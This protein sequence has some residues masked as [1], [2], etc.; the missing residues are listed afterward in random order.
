[1]QLNINNNHKKWEISSYYGKLSLCVITKDYRIDTIKIETVVK[2]SIKNEASWFINKDIN[3]Q[4]E[5]LDMEVESDYKWLLFIIKQILDN[6]EKY[7]E[8]SDTIK[9]YVEIAEKEK[10]LHIEDNGIGI[11]QEDLERVFEKSFT[12]YN[13]RVKHH[14]T[15][16][17]LYLSQKLAKKL[18]QYITIA[19]EYNK[20]TKVSIHFPKWNDYYKWDCN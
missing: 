2:E 18:G 1:M 13:G 14:S 20:G 16:M 9:I 6:S 15:G 11:K 4:L 10:L 12:G 17:G 3:L 5:R 19:S 8:K 7:T